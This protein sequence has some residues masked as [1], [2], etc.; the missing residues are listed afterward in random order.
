[1]QNLG[2]R[3]E[4]AVLQMYKEEMV[5]GLYFKPNTEAESCSTCIEGKLTVKPFPKTEI[6]Y[7][8]QPLDLA[9][10]DVCGPIKPNSLGN[11]QYVLTLIDDYSRYTVCYLL[12]QKTKL[13]IK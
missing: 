11:N 7:T 9:H 12:K 1:M 8:K 6:A 10:S 3:D 2:H 4:K 13:L 5:R